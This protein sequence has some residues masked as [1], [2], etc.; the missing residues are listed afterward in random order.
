MQNVGVTD[1]IG[2][3]YCYTGTGG[4]PALANI[5]AIID[6]G[7]N[8]TL[9]ALYT[10]PRGYVAYLCRGELGQSRGQI[11][12]VTRSAYYSRRYGKVFTIKKRI[13]T[14][15]QGSSIYQDKRS[16]PDV[17]PSLTDIKLTVESV[18]ANNTGI[19]GT[20]D[21]L[22]IEESLFPDSFLQTIGQ[23]GY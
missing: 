13:D 10:V 20:L 23:P 5:R 11:A 8:Q 19:F 6:N 18:S 7:N 22:L 17:I 21:I 4:V 1:L 12:G 15:N 3:C 16:F 2:T 9:M 14:T